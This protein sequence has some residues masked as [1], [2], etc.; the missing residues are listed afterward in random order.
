MASENLKG[1][2]PRPSLD[3]PGDPEVQGG[4]TPINKVRPNDAPPPPTP[5]KK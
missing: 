1:V 4:L 5:P 2:T 3:T